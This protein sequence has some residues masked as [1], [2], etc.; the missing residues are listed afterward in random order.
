MG[1][2]DGFDLLDPGGWPGWFVDCILCVI[3]EA[4]QSFID[5]VVSFFQL[6][7]GA[8][9]EGIIFFITSIQEGF[10][11]IFDIFY[12]AMEWILGQFGITAPFVM[13]VAVILF[14]IFVVFAVR[15]LMWTGERLYELL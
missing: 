13:A 14:L 10:I 3:L 4:I 7:F 15:M 6:V 8:I 5:A 2:C 12:G 9:A 1:C 11:F